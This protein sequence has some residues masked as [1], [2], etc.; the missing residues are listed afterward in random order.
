MGVQMVAADMK[1][2]LD[3]LKNKSR[4]VAQFSDTSLSMCLKDAMSL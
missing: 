1:V 2:G 4:T 3:I